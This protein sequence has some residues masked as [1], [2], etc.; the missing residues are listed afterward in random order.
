MIRYK[1]GSNK[2]KPL[3]S[4][5]T[6]INHCSQRADDSR[7]WLPPGPESTDRS[8]IHY[9]CSRHF[10]AITALCDSPAVTLKAVD[11]GEA[12]PAVSADIVCAGAGLALA[13]P[14]GPECG[15]PGL[16]CTLARIRNCRF[17][18]SL[19]GFIICIDVIEVCVLRSEVG[20]QV[21]VAGEVPGPVRLRDPGEGGGDQVPGVG[22]HGHDGGSH[23][24]R[25]PGLGGDI[26]GCHHVSCHHV[27]ISAIT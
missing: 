17:I 20:D 14:R 22:G 11:A 16:C 2:Q 25:V 6:R 10:I 7:Q 1:L 27:R 4:K 18:A 13:R 23:E 24:V 15:H 26:G 3:S 5:G 9:Y 12:G 21:R 19:K 8:P